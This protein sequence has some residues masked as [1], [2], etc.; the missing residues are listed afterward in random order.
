MYEPLRYHNLTDAQKLQVLQAFHTCE[1]TP[2][3][4]W[5]KTYFPP[6]WYLNERSYFIKPRE[7]LACVV[8]RN[9]LR[10]CY[11]ADI[12][13][14]RFI[15]KCKRKY[16]ITVV[17]E[18]T[19]R[20]PGR[21]L[22]SV[23]PLL[24]DPAVGADIRLL[25]V[26]RDPRASINSRIKLKWFPEYDNPYFEQRVQDYCHVIFQN[27]AV[28]KALSE[29]FKHKY[30][31][32]FYRDIAARPFDT[33]KE[34]F[35]FAGL[36]MTEKTLHWITNMTNPDKRE[37]MKESRR[38]YSLVRDSEANIDKWRSESPPERTRVIEEICQPLIKLL[39][40]I[41]FEQEYILSN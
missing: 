25:H 17:K 19:N 37:E 6:F 12:L 26:V 40:K 3:T 30:K 23:V 16:D 13:V 38:P 27:I 28:G 32:V 33:A 18:L 1:F 22:S 15:D 34:I 21:T 20:L 36:E 9:G 10:R 11:P 24:I 31:L 8:Y 5:E 7:N 4:L 29:A 41:S 14:Q 2:S 35:K 39:E